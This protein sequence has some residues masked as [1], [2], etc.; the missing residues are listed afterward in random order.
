MN[1]FSHHPERQGYIIVPLTQGKVTRISR[2]DEYLMQY[3]WHF[4]EGYA[5]RTIRENDR[6]RNVFMHRH[7]VQVIMGRPLQN[8]EFVEHK[9]GDKL[10]NTRENLIYPLTPSEHGQRSKLQKNNT[11]GYKGV[12]YDKKRN[13]WRAYIAKNLRVKTIGYYDTAEDAALAY[14][15]AAQE[16]YGEKARINE[17]LPKE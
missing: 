6:R 5:Q 12:S 13:K 1:M 4:H 11:S 10:D 14:N 2:D 16:H 7:I 17:I 9:N 15:N 3:R 8:N